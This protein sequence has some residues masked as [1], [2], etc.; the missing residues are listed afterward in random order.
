MKGFY[1]AQCIHSAVN[2]QWW[3][4]TNLRKLR[5]LIRVDVSHHLK[6]YKLPFTNIKRQLN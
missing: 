2:S 5:I 3:S 6:L 4:S 1:S